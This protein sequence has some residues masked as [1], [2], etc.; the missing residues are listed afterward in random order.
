MNM[1]YCQG[2]GHKIHET[3][4]ACP[5]CG[6]PQKTKVVAVVKRNPTTLGQLLFSFEGRISRS[7]YWLEYCLP[8]NVMAG[9][10]LLVDSSGS[11][12]A[13]LL[14]LFLYPTLAVTSKRCHDV[15]R[16]G[17]FMLILLIPILGIWPFI[18]LGFIRG[19]R[20]ENQYGIDPL[21]IH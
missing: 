6:A 1:I 15:N 17:W 19:T 14:L 16:S 8:V 18:E 5:S 13:L 4:V 7:R 12:T 20:A 3:A 11:L 21:G 10:L 2:C 9:L